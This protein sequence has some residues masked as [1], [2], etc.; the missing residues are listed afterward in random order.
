MRS[1]RTSSAAALVIA[2]TSAARAE[3]L[4]IV[5][6]EI[7]VATDEDDAD[8]SRIEGQLS[9]L[10]VDVRVL[11]GAD[12]ARLPADGALRIAFETTD[13]RSRRV[14]LTN[15]AS[16]F[17]QARRIELPNG[18]A[19]LSAQR[20]SV[21]LTARRMIKAQLEA[22]PTPPPEAPKAVSQR[23]AFGAL[24]GAAATADIEGAMVGLRGEIRGT[25]KYTDLRFDV[26][27]AGVHRAFERDGYR[28]TVEGIGPVAMVGLERAW[29]TSSLYAGVGAA[30]VFGVR[31]VEPGAGQVGAPDAARSFVLPRIEVAWSRKVTERFALGVALS[32]ETEFPRATYRREGAAG[33]EGLA[34]SSILE[35][36]IALQGAWDAEAR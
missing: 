31:A 14:T 23:W 11:R 34:E 12:L 18:P 5:P 9:D 13:D 16:G 8:R 33:L 28:W 32:A 35:P 25:A 20:E 29:G 2:A 6:V 7:L 36:A 30:Y 15:T 27:L 3:A 24:A 26:G 1:L 10:A 19:A 4:R 22:S 21:A 17:V